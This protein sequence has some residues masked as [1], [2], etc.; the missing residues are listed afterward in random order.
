M[1]EWS[2]VYALARLLTGEVKGATL[3]GSVKISS[4]QVQHSISEAPIEYRVSKDTISVIKDSSTAQK[5]ERKQVSEIATLLLADIREKSTRTF[6]S[7]SGDA[8]VTA[9]GFKGASAVFRDDVKVR[10]DG[11][12]SIAWSGLSVKSFLGARPTLLNAS[13]A[14]NFVYK[15]SGSPRALK[16]V[17]NLRLL[18][19]RPLFKFF[20][21]N[22]IVLNF[23][24]M[25]SE[26]FR[27]SLISFSPKLVELV[28]TL[29]SQAAF[30]RRKPLKEVWIGAKGSG[31][32]GAYD[33]APELL[34]F[35]G[36]VGLGLQPATLWE[37]RRLGFGGFLIVNANGGVE[38]LNEAGMEALGA[39]LFQ[40]LRFEWG[41]R[42]RHKFGIPYQEGGEV[43]LKLNL[44]LRY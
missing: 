10:F 31:P 39:R 1:G 26:T 36:A 44:Q 30:Q 2:E 23:V 5:I 40:E 43:Y 17:S 19:M 35:L 22:S 3:R 8:L 25:D 7:K 4:A 20:T 14:T 18:T 6:M 29:L 28:A 12:K 41:S 24:S 32:D 21:E 13:P 38:L 27:Q 11:A 33:V 42:K 15:L 9:L 16:Q 37:S 34:N